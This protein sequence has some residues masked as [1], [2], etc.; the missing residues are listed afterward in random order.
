MM[1]QGSISSSIDLLNELA[2]AISL[3]TTG[4]VPHTRD[5]K[6]FAMVLK[7]PYGVHLG[8]AP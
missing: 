7:E 3:A 8:I 2:G 1:A 4:I 5:S 6:T